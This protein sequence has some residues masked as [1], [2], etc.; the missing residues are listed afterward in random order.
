MFSKEFQ[1][2][3][4]VQS[5][6]SLSQSSLLLHCC[7]ATAMESSGTGDE[8]VLSLADAFIFINYYY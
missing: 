7:D 5:S 1:V 3:G 6:S 4:A 2:I 8:R